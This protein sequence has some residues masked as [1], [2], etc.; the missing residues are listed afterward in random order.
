[1]SEEQ[2]NPW[3]N[4]QPLGWISFAPL[5]TIWKRLAAESMNN[6][7]LTGYFIAP[8]QKSYI[9]SRFLLSHTG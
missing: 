5:V 2:I 7:A 6:N 1:Y 3:I 4:F 9:L 8:C